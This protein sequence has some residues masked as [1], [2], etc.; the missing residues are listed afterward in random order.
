MNLPEL[1]PDDVDVLS[2]DLGFHLPLALLVGFGPR[3]G[4]A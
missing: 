1:I 4:L 2:L 3:H